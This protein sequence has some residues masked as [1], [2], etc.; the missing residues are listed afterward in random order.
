MPISHIKIPLPI[1]ILLF[2]MV[3]KEPAGRNCGS[4]ARN[5]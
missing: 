3:A 1:T 2:V 5:D 4:V